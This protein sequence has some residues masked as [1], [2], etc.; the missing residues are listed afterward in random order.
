[1]PGYPDDGTLAWGLG[2]VFSLPAHDI[3]I[4]RRAPNPLASTFLTEVVEVEVAGV[5]KRLFCKYG[6]GLDP[7]NPRANPAHIRYEIEVY[8]DLLAV[9]GMSTPRFEGAVMASV[10]SAPWLVLRQ[11][12][13][14]IPFTETAHPDVLSAAEW[15]GRFHRVSSK[16]RGATAWELPRHLGV[17]DYLAPL[18]GAIVMPSKQRPWLA[19]LL[20][21][22]R[23][24]APALV[25]DEVLIHGEFYPNNILTQSGT[26]IP[27]DWQHSRVAAGE[28]DL[29][30]LCEG[31]PNR[32]V[33]LM[34]R[35][36]CVGRGLDHQAP[37]FKKR[38]LAARLYVHLAWFRDEPD[39]IDALRNEA[40]RLGLTSPASLTPIKGRRR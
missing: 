23:E 27:V 37:A 15:L 34:A 6:V 4:A 14:A 1:M 17:G 33:S 20:S 18:D 12:E 30:T 39:R 9:V 13:A 11:I 35:G 26:V 21:R 25:G 38:F 10:V 24:I 2:Q 31:W 19:K 29:A 7:A 40:R 32:Q 36:Y 28:I 8:R 3:E 16:L 5:T 22:Y